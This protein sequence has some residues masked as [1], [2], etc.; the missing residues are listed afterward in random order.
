MAAKE[1]SACEAVECAISDLSMSSTKVIF[2]SV[3]CPSKSLGLEIVKT[4]RK[5]AIASQMVVSA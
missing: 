2:G 3:I 1:R 4:E 5:R